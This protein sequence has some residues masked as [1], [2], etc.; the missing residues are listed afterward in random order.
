VE[1][2]EMLENLDIEN[3]EISLSNKFANNQNQSNSVLKKFLKEQHSMDVKFNIDI[4]KL[5]SEDDEEESSAN[6][7]VL[8]NNT[9]ESNYCK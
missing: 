5:L 8:Q 1:F 6:L 3:I 2:K 7:S 4:E 9:T